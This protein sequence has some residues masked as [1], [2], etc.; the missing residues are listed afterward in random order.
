MPQ[1]TTQD[2]SVPVARS[3]PNS[4]KNLHSGAQGQPGSSFPGPEHAERACGV[5]GLPAEPLPQYKT[6]RSA[7]MGGKPT[8][9]DEY[10]ATVKGERRAALDRLRKAIRTVVPKAKECIS[11]GM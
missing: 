5:Q 8:T 7:P 11:Y 6:P 3:F 2:S 4:C 10:L 1:A 9:I